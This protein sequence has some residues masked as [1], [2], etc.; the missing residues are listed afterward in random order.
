MY[1]H[2]TDAIE[3]PALLVMGIAFFAS[4]FLWRLLPWRRIRFRGTPLFVFVV[5]VFLWPFMK[6]GAAGKITHWWDWTPV[7]RS[8]VDAGVRPLVVAS[9]IPQ[10]RVYKITKWLGQYNWEGVKDLYKTLF[11]LQIV[12][13]LEPE[14][15]R[16]FWRLLISGNRYQDKMQYAFYDRVDLLVRGRVKTLLDGKKYFLGQV[17]DGRYIPLKLVETTSRDQYP[18]IPFV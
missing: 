14:S 12:V 16:G 17:E 1:T 18:D 2:L 8:E 4:V 10:Q 11:V 15:Y 13:V 6:L 3:I 5:D 7:P 9:Q